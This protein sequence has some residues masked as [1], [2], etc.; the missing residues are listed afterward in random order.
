MIF[1]FFNFSNKEGFET[2]N[3]KKK[4]DSLNKIMSILCS[5]FILYLT[6]RKKNLASNI[7]KKHAL[8]KT[9]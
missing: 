6:L 2:C 7:I 5:D 3:E 1:D 8:G 4:K 9:H